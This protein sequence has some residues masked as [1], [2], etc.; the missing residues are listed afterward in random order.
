MSDL[1]VFFALVH[2]HGMWLFFTYLLTLE[3]KRKFTLKQKNN[4]G[5]D[6]NKNN[7]NTNINNNKK[8]LCFKQVDR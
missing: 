2:I 7:N 3:R 1:I 8:L 4:K 6:N 5:N